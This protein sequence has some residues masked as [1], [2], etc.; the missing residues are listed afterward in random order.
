MLQDT[1][2]RLPRTEGLHILQKRDALGAREL[3]TWRLCLS[4][5]GSARYITGDE[6]TILVLQHGKGRVC[7]GD[8]R[9]DVS[10]GSVFAQRATALYLPPAVP[11][12]VT[13][14]SALEAIL[15]S[16]PA[17][18]GGQPVLVAPGEVQVNERG[19]DGYTRQV[20][21]IFVR[22][23]HVRR[24]MVGETFNPPG[25]WSSFPPHKH[26]GRNGEAALE[27]VYYYRLDPPAGFGH[28]M[29]YTNDGEDLYT[30]DPDGTNLTQITDDAD[31]EH[32]PQWG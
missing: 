32:S 22:D 6:E 30:A 23:A 13:A 26:D 29:M 14:D 17:P 3:T 12:S 18:S 21:D 27:E 11:L 15:V 28:Q 10:R 9:W 2:F 7:A 5:G 8:G 31:I 25:H 20:H 16:T 4:P 19:R 1:L 24:L